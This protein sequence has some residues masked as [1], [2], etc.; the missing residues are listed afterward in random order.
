MKR[1]GSVTSGIMEGKRDEV[2]FR[3]LKGA[4]GSS[5]GSQG[6]LEEVIGQ[7]ILQPIPVV[8]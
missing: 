1:D 6:R 2:A 7:E 8:G 3:W 4:E 5:R